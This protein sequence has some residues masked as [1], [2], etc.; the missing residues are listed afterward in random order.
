[1]TF[2]APWA[3]VIGGFAAAGT[4]LLHLVARQR[5]AAYLLPTTR[6]IPDRRTLVSR[7]ARRPRDLLLLALRVVL[8]LSAAA[9][10]ARPV[11]A[12]SRAARARLIM[13]DRSGSVAASR[14]AIERA[15]ALLADGLPTPLIALDSSATYFGDAAR[16]LDSLMRDSSRTDHVGSLSAALVAA[17]RA[18]PL[19]GAEADSVELVV[20]S[21]MMSEQLDAA[22]D[23]VRAQWPGRITI[24]RVEA[25]VDSAKAWSLDR[26]VALDDPLG[27]ALARVPVAPAPS[28]VRLVRAPLGMRDSVFA[29]AGGAVVR[30]D[31]VAAPMRA[32]ALAMGD[33]VVVATMARASLPARGRVIARW[34]DGSAAAMEETLGKG[35]VREIGIGVP[36]AGDLSLRP[37]FQRLVRGLM[38]PCSGA[39]PSVLA[40]SASVMRLAGTGALA[41]GDALLG[42]ERPASTIVPWLLALALACALAELALRTRPT[43]EAA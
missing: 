38:A 2:L 3:L 4:V 28:A 23:S 14:A 20:V 19:L 22:T 11:L 27:P 21:P 25:R 18:G 39:A 36:R 6:F 32:T 37:P 41:S 26:A 10:F 15:R 8:L 30:W 34:S 17:R 16:A 12:P 31:S 1:M 42:R 5:P 35:C 7:V 13:L 29:S 33:D 40:D 24:T 9:A 43:R